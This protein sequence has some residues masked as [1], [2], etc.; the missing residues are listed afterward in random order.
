GAALPYTPGLDPAA[1]DRGVDPCVDFYAFAC[2]GWMKANPLPADESNWSVFT[3]LHDQNLSLLRQILEDAARIGP[4]RDPVQR[5]IGDFSA[6]CMDEAVI[7]RQGAQPLAALAGEIAAI[8]SRD[9]L[10]R[11][12]AHLQL[13]S[14]VVPG[15]SAPFRIDFAQDRRNSS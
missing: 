14:E 4:G 8:A 2:G 13:A 15:A 5:E 1:V 9:D 11:V 10:A 6:S 7:E 12:V 3:K